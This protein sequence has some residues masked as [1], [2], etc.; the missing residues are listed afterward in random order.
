MSGPN[1]ASLPSSISPSISKP[2]DVPLDGK[3]HPSSALALRAPYALAMPI[4]CP[5]FTGCVLDAGL[6]C[7]R[8]L[9]LV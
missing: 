9:C 1:L 2:T 3:E 4:L 7:G 5:M 6:C 8:L